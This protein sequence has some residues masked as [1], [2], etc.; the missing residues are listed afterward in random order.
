MRCPD[1][2]CT[3]VGTAYT[4]AQWTR[5]HGTAYAIASGVYTSTYGGSRVTEPTIFGVRLRELRE[6]RGWTQE[7]VAE[8]AGLAA[9]VVSHFE[10]GVR[11]KPSADNLVKISKALG[12]TADYLLGRSAQ[13]EVSDERVSALL[14]SLSDAPGE[15]YERFIEMGEWLLA[16]RKG[17]NGPE[18]EGDP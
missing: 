15:T 10:T 1:R 16:R 9:S 4:E 2:P 6:A 17:T 8:R 11:G 7:E 14:R 13:P 3:H 18:G 12:V 5:V